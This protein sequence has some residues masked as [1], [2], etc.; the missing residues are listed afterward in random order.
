MSSGLRSGAGRPRGCVRGGCCIT[1]VG[2]AT[3]SADGAA[4]GRALLYSPAAQLEALYGH[5][6]L[7]RRHDDAS[8]IERGTTTMVYFPAIPRGGLIPSSSQTIVGDAAP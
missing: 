4:C 3:R 2:A 1:F 7:L 6:L 5:T 8:H